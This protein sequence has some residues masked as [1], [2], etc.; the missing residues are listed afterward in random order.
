MRPAFVVNRETEKE[1]GREESN[2][3]SVLVSA[4]LRSG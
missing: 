4:K 2:A 1:D 3:P